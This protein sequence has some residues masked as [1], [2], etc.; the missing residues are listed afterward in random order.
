[1]AVNALP[2]ARLQVGSHLHRELSIAISQR[3]E[4]RTIRFLSCESAPCS[5][6]GGHTPPDNC[7]SPFHPGVKVRFLFRRQ[8]GLLLTRDRERPL[9]IRLSVGGIRFG[10]YRRLANLLVNIFG[11]RP[12]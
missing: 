10:P 4:P 2:V 6:G 12:L 1:M 7:Q 8:F 3:S 5:K 11:N 9:E